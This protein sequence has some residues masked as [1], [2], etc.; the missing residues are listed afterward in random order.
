NKNIVYRISPRS[1]PQAQ[2][3]FMCDDGRLGYK[4]INSK[5]RL[6]APVAGAREGTNGKPAA[7]TEILGQGREVLRKAAAEDG[8][9]IAAGLSPWMTCEEA[10]LLAKFLKILSKEVRFSRGPVPVEGKDALYPKGRRGE[11]PPA[12]Q[13]QFSIHAEKCPNR[14]G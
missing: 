3:H 1:N 10:F 9:S 14:K 6:A 4:Y 13:V 7:W 8:Q 12:N 2:G 11:D 5:D